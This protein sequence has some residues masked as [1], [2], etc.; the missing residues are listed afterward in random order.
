MDHE[1]SIRKRWLANEARVA[2][3]DPSAWEVWRY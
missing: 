1:P 3:L 2:V